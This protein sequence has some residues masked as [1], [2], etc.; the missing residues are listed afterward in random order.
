MKK[1]LACMPVFPVLFSLMAVCIVTFDGMPLLI[2]T[3]MA[4]LWLLMSV[5]V[6]PVA[7]P[8]LQERLSHIKWWHFPLFAVS[9][10]L[11]AFTYCLAYYLLTGQRDPEGDLLAVV[12]PC[13]AGVM[14]LLACFA[15][16][17]LSHKKGKKR[18]VS[19]VFLRYECVF[20][21]Q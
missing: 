19:S 20:S 6:F 17:Y 18:S 10:V 4:I 14:T 12:A 1:W 15:V 3:N 21:D 16:W 8:V 9:N 5:F 7:M 2:S 11:G 13:A